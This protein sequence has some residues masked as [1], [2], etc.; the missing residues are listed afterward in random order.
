MNE[1]LLADARWRPTQEGILGQAEVPPLV[2]TN[3]VFGP[4]SAD[5]PLPELDVAVETGDHRD[6]VYMTERIDKPVGAYIEFHFENFG[7]TTCR[8]VVRHAGSV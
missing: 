1:A 3:L 6:L 7:N 8:V 5:R 4:F 2:G